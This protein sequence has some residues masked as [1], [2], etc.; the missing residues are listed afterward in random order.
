MVYRTKTYIAGDWSGDANAINQL[1]QWNNSKFWNL[2]FVDAHDLTQARDTSLNCSI[3]RSLKERM[4]SSKTF[5]LIG[6]EKTNSLTAG[7]CRFCPSYN[8]WNSHCVKGYSIDYRSFVH[9]E[10]DKASEA[11]IKII[12]L[13]NNTIVLKQKCPDVLRCVGKHI[14]MIYRGNDGEY[15]WNYS[16]INEALRS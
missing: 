16:A 11:G 14:A 12:V 7:S 8:S 1:Y 5:V 6:G 13:Y 10:C 15:Y 4:D 2:S 3:K 9:Y